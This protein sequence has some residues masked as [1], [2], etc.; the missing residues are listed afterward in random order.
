M[1]VKIYWMTWGVIG[2]A[3][4]LLFAAGVFTQ[5]TAV[6]FGFI[7]FGMVFMGMMGVLPVMV[8]HPA[9]VLEK[10]A[11]QPKLQPMTATHSKMFGTWKS[12]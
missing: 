1:L 5:L 10:K 11:K 6:V 7:A 9:P 2:A 8:S 3:A 12:A 4:L